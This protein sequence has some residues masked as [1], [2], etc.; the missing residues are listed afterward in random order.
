MRYGLLRIVSIPVIAFADVTFFANLLRFRSNMKE[1][2]LIKSS[3]LEYFRNKD[4]H[5]EMS[6]S[7]IS[8]P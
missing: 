6:N 8:P 4:E 7:I 2:Q 5:K 1:E 3:K